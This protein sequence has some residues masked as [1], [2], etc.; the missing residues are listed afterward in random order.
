MI[1]RR[2]FLRL[3]L[4]CALFSGAAFSQD[5]ELRFCLHSEPKTFDPLLVDDRVLTLLG[6]VQLLQQN[7]VAA[8]ATL[9]KA[10]AVNS[11]YW[12]AH[13]LLANAYLRLKK[14]EGAR[15]EAELA[16]AQ[17]KAGAGAANLVLG[18]SLVNLG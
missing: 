6:H 12:T 5:G 9:E 11:E 8:A 3:L 7:Y 15:E 10:V 4:C 17:G 18:E 13:N 16:V 14:Y 2:A 1:V